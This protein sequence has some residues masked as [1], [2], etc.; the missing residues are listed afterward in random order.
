MIRATSFLDAARRQEEAE[1]EAARAKEE[2][3]QQEKNRLKAMEERQ[4]RTE[5]FEMYS[6]D[7]YINDHITQILNKGAVIEGIEETPGGP[8]LQGEHVSLICSM[9]EVWGCPVSEGSTQGSWN[10]ATLSAWKHWLEN[11]GMSG[12]RV[13]SISLRRFMDREYFQ[14]HLQFLLPVG[15]E[16]EQSSRQTFEV[17]DA[18]EEDFESYVRCIDPEAGGFLCF[19]LP[20]SLA[21]AVHHRLK[22]AA[23]AAATVDEEAKEGEDGESKKSKEPVLVRVDLLTESVV[24]LL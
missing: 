1:A 13:D 9:L 6:A 2:E 21:D 10:A 20:V 17:H 11:H 24:E 18:N 23:A 3:I 4:R 19:T 12:H 5:L 14:E 15:E 22:A 7:L 16:V 8:P